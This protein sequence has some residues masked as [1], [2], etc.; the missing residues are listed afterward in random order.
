MGK[1][2]IKKSMTDYIARNN[3]PR[4]QLAFDVAVDGAIEQ[5][6][7]PNRMLVTGDYTGDRDPNRSYKT[8][9][10]R[11]VIEIDKDNF[12]EVLERLSPRLELDLV[13]R[14]ADDNSKLKV[15]LNFTHI[16][17]FEPEKLAMQVPAL[18][19]LLE[20]RKL[21]NDFLTRMDGNPRTK[22]VLREALENEEMLQILRE[23]LG[24]S[25]LKGADYRSASVE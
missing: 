18:R 22:K 4:V 3:P 1:K 10:E 14:L 2:I 17:D 9:E 20:K 25:S 5:R 7:I 13:N 8:L 12:N 16:E 19:R 21:L 15:E 11:R 24:L 23:E 6:E